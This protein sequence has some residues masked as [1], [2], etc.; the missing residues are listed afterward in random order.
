MSPDIIPQIH[1]WPAACLKVQG[2][3]IEAEA[4]YFVLQSRGQETPRDYWFYCA[5]VLA[6]A[7]ITSGIYRQVIQ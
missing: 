1:G 7:Y 2:D 3:A 4:R 6:A 5:Q